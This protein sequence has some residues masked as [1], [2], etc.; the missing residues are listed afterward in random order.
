MDQFFAIIKAVEEG[1]LELTEDKKMMLQFFQMP[2]EE[3]AKYIP[4]GIPNESVAMWPHL[5]DCWLRNLPE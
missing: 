2:E 1:K 4:K 3:R 5:A